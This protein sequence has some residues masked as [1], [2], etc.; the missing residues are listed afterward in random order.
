MYTVNCTVYNAYWYVRLTVNS[1]GFMQFGTYSR[2][3]GYLRSQL[4][5][6]NILF[7]FSLLFFSVGIICDFNEKSIKDISVNLKI[8]EL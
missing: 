7:D 6:S 1:R 5:L 2:E 3:L 4:N 8:V